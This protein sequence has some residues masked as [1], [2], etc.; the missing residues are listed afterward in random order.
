MHPEYP[1]LFIYYMTYLDK[2]EESDCQETCYSK[3]D[4][5]TGCVCA[6]K[7]ELSVIHCW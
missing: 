4:I 3:P 2:R 5:Y 7:L 1:V 6:H